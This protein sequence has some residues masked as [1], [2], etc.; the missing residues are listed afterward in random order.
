MDA[1]V[2]LL[3]SSGGALD[4][5]PALALP[6]SAQIRLVMLSGVAPVKGLR[7][8]NPDAVYVPSNFLRR[9][10][11][12][13]FSVAP[14][15][16]FVTYHGVSRPERLGGIPDRNCFRLIYPSH[17]S[18]G[19]NAALEIWRRLRAEDARFELEICGGDRLWG[20][21]NESQPQAEPGL[22]YS[23]LLGQRA[24]F[25][26]FEQAGF[27]IQLQ[28]IQEGF[29]I[30]VAEGMAAGCIVVASP[31]GAYTE[32][33]R[34]G[35]NGFLIEGSHVASETHEKA[36]RLIRDL[37]ARPDAATRVRRNAAAFPLDWDNVAAT[38]MGHWEWLLSGK[39]KAM[40]WPRCLL[41][42]GWPLPLA[43]GFHCAECGHYSVEIAYR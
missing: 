14:E 38:W 35:F 17:P 22:I 8:A 30:S 18:K 37:T 12:E 7:E 25:E 24:L 40:E 23:G 36:A 43:D 5:G 15:K 3:H 33:V 29:G 10:V 21:M 4:L 26:R 42:K 32:T 19:L 39:Q 16:T 2:L 6:V 11:T 1:D 13:T 27:V 20:G 41:C 34:H 9:Y 28:A 31:A